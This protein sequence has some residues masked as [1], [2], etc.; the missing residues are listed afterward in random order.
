MNGSMRTPK[1]DDRSISPVTGLRTGTLP[2]VRVS[3]STCARAMLMRWTWRSKAPA[4]AGGRAA[5]NGPPVASPM[6]AR[7]DLAGIDAEIGEHAAD[8]PRLGVVALLHRLERDRL[9]RL[10]AV[11]R[12]LQAGE[13]AVD[14]ALASARRCGRRSARVA[15]DGAS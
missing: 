3:R 13:R 10:D 7:C 8:A 1:P 2:S 5:T 15:V 4:S 9:A 14:A 6:P 12:G 11:E